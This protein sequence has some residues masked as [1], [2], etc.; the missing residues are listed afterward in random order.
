MKL[1]PE[2][3]SCFFIILMLYHVVSFS[4]PQSSIQHEGNKN[5]FFL[6]MQVMKVFTY[7]LSIFLI[8]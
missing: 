6:Q 2:N 4:P 1:V 7:S 3:S 8:E 5:N